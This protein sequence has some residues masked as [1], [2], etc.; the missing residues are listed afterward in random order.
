MPYS[1][2]RQDLDDNQ[3]LYFGQ[4]GTEGGL[5]SSLTL[6]VWLSFP[7]IDVELNQMGLVQEAFFNTEWLFLTIIANLELLAT[8]L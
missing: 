4:E 2:A 5:Q 6:Q 3:V 1:V 7:P 8:N